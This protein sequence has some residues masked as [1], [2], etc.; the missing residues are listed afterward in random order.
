MLTRTSKYDSRA[1]FEKK[2]YTYT[3]KNDDVIIKMLTLA[4]F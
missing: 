3:T 2:T 1:I 4:F